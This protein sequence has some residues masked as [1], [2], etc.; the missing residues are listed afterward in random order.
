MLAHRGMLQNTSCP[1]CTTEEETILH[2]LRDCEFVRSFWKSIGITD[3][4]FFQEGDLYVWM[5]HGID[6]PFTFSFLA[7]I[8]WIWRARNHLCMENELISYF[9]LRMCTEN[10][11]HLLKKCFLKH[12]ES[13]TTR[14]VRWNARGGSGMILN[15]D[16]SSIDNPGISGFGGLIQNCNSAWIYGFAG[17]IGFSNILHA[18][19]MA[20]YHGLTL[21]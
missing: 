8:W 16:G 6:G 17:Y 19:L 10:L 11:V 18:E 12:F 20:V 3:H 9:S 13:P 2:C 15:V 4:T 5:K 14:T 1:R 7:A 21:A